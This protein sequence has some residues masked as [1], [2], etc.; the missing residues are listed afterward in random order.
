[1]D[2]PDREEYTVAYYPRDSFPAA[3]QCVA[4]AQAREGARCPDPF[5]NATLNSTGYAMPAASSSMAVV[6]DLGRSMA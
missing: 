2:A 4:P 3:G 6:T 5:S 1:M